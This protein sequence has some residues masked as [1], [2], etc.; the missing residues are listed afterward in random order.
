MG[1]M[2]DYWGVP[3]QE[4]ELSLLQFAKNELQEK[5][6]SILS[7]K[8]EVCS[9]AG[10]LTMT[11]ILENQNKRIG[12]YLRD[13]PKNRK[14]RGPPVI[15]M[16]SLR[17]E[18]KTAEDLRNFVLT[19]QHDFPMILA[20]EVMAEKERIEYEIKE[21]YS[22]LYTTMMKD[23]Y[24]TDISSAADELRVRLRKI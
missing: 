22:F 18:M 17:P 13:G 1:T 21:I 20:P 23:L 5:G 2:S 14:S 10:A 9:G 24:D 15:S 12:L 3:E 8:V 6:Y 11:A 16:L 19:H 7:E 4:Y